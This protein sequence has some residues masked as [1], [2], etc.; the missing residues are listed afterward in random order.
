M[1]STEPVPADD[2]GVARAARILRAGGL[3]AFPT[4]TVYGLGADAGDDVAVAKIYAAKERPRFNPLIAH[5]PDADAAGREGVFD[6]L[7]RRLAEAFWPGPLTLVVPRR[8]TGRVCALAR[9]GLESVAL[10]VPDHP[11]AQALLRAADR[12]IVAPSANRSGRI[13]PTRAAHVA[14]DLGGRVDLILEG[15]ATRVGVESTI[16]SC[17]DG[18]ARLLRPGGLAREAIEAALEDANE[19][20][21]RVATYSLGRLKAGR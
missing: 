21:G 17:V 5:A 11:V 4:E 3:V 9:A 15:G 10:R 13:S 20:V 12:P 18:V 19:Y 2:A 6:D 16:V 7:A 8:A 1:R 14:A